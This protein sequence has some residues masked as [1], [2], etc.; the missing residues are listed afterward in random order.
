VNFTKKGKQMNQW[1]RMRT[2]IEGATFDGVDC[3]T[4]GEQFGHG[5]AC[6]IETAMFYYGFAR[7]E[8]PR[9]TIHSGTHKG[10]D[11]A[12]IAAGLQD[13]G[14]E[15]GRPSSGGHILT[16][17]V[18]DHNPRALW[19]ALGLRNINHVIGDSR[20]PETYVSKVIP[21][22]PID[23]AHMD[24]DHSAE[25]LLAEFH[26]VLP[27][28]N[29]GRCWFSSHDTRLDTRLSPGIQQI[30]KELRNMRDDGHGWRLISHVPMRNLRGLDMILLS[31]ETF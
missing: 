17:D 26:C 23:W 15:I 11:V 28:L 22:E 7:R 8:K 27:L 20:L 3:L 9:M 19:Q 14:D 16:I 1:E 21:N 30:L 6:E 4:A 29:K 18:D 12:W 10:Y 31:N 24:A 13:N 2:L 25:S 5:N